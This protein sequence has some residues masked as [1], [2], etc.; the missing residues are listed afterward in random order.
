MKVLSLVFCLLLFH[1]DV[2]AQALMT[3]DYPIVDNSMAFF[4]NSYDT[5][6][7][8][9][10]KVASCIQNNVSFYFDTNGRLERHILI[11]E[12]SATQVFSFFMIAK[13]ILSGWKKQTPNIKSHFSLQI[14]KRTLMVY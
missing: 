8:R 13:V 11:P 4:G 7:L 14:T 2:N 5:A 3:F 6:L 10:N 12:D 1:L 9:K